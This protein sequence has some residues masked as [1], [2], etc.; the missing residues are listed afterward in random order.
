MKAIAL[1]ATVFLIASGA[2]AKGRCDPALKHRSA[3]EVLESHRAALA[4]GD[5]ATARCNYAE[6]AVV[7]NDGGVTTGRDTIIGELQFLASLFGGLI[8]SVTQEVIVSVLNDRAE[9]GRVLFTI[10]TQCLDI[11]DGVDTYVIKNG[12]IQ[13]QTAHGFPVFKCGPPPGP[14]PG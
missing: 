13:A 3:A 11:P 5:W 2:H 8:P 7:I 14:P 10:T 4:A 9:M 12:Q 1:A 6:D